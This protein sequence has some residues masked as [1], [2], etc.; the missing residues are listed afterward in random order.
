MCGIAGYSG[1]CDEQFLSYANEVQSHRGPDNQ[2]YWVSDDT[3]IG[4]AHQRLSIIDLSEHAH[5]PMHDSKTNVVISYNGELY[6]FKELRE[7]LSDSHTFQTH[8]DTEVI[9]QSYLKW[10][11]DCVSKFNGMFAFAI[12]DPRNDSLFIARDH[13]GI[14]PLYYTQADSFFAFAS[15]LKSFKNILTDTEIDH[16]SVAR[17]LSYLWC[18][19]PNT[20]LTAVKKLEP[21]HGLI[22]SKGKIQKKWKFYTLPF[23]SSP[24]I[25]DL[26]HAIETTEKALKTAVQRQLVSDVPVGAFL[27][28]G[29]DSSTIAYFANQALDTPLQC[30]TI[31]VT[32]PGQNDGFTDD[33]PYAK[34]VAKFINSPLEIITVTPE[35]LINAI[36]SMIYHLDEPQADPAPLNAMLIAEQAK[37]MGYKVLL[38]GAGGDDIFTGYRRHQALYLEKYW[39]FLPQPLRATLKSLSSLVP[40]QHPQLRRF[41]KMFEYA[42]LPQNERLVSY[43][44]WSNP[45]DT[46]DLLHPD[47]KQTVSKDDIL[48]P[49]LNNIPE[50]VSKTDQMLA[51][52]C[53]NF[54]ADHNLNYTDKT[55]MIHGVEV[56]VPF[57]DIDL[58]HQAAQLTSDL[59]Q[60]K[61]QGKYILKKVMERHLP[62]HIIYRP[63]SGFGAPLRQWLK[64]SPL[65]DT[66]MDLLSTES[67][68]KRGLFNP[69]AVQA[70]IQQND[71]NKVDASYTLFS[72]MCIE[73]WLRLFHK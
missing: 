42:N 32:T 47:I 37:K 53:L 44:L 14:K 27:S 23:Q 19:A 24:P 52:E 25:N 22:V 21:G 8:S 58:V 57:L 20:M 68:T 54:L 72:L 65:K 33:L 61:M 30:F 5:Q 59:K 39:S 6:N 64:T 43:F 1:D 15:E 11:T 9:L 7:T 16:K 28:G 49:L 63:K 40:S 60:H 46:L 2:D 31:D 26:N 17:H 3:Q 50:N 29:L 4:L 67:L 55:S 51:L 71:T 12:W 34:E 38:S 10:G 66:M 45:N 13:L 36:E 70:L 18:P 41:K 62:H 69:Q 56:R 48:S 35:T 73:W